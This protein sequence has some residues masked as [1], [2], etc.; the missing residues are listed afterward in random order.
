MKFVHT[1]DLHLNVTLSH[2]SFKDARQHEHRVQEL[3][4]AFFRL[5]EYVRKHEVE[6][7]LIAGDMFDDANMRFF[8]MQTLFKRLGELPAEVFL[9]IGNHDT[10]LHDEAYQSLIRES[11][12]RMFD[13]DTPRHRLESVDVYGLNT[14]DF[15]EARLNELNGMLDPSKDNI[16]LLHGD[17][18]NKQDEHYLTD[19][20]TLAET[21][22]DYVALGHIHKHAFLKPHIAYSGN[23][24]PLDFSETDPRGFIEGTLE[25]GRLNASFRKFQSRAFLVHTIEIDDDD[26]TDTILMSAR[27]ELS[28]SDASH[29]FNRV[30]IT[31]YHHPELALD[32]SWLKRALEE[33][34][35]YVEIRDE[36]EPSIALEDMKAAHEDDAIGQLIED[37]EQDASKDEEDHEALLRAIRALLETGRGA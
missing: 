20:D 36:S 30:L 25:D 9:L 27:S 8:E 18:S 1:A 13:K 31:G 17:V 24:E 26:T 21:A 22:F 7:L 29:A 11:G 5:L 32:T 12:V 10:F 33:D 19:P 28:E 4:D 3:R 37:Y 14:R 15:T 35:H 2:A 34:V 23:L 6:L 16:L